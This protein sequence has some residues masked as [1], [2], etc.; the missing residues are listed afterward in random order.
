[1]DYKDT[2]WTMIKKSRQNYALMAPYFILFFTFTV[3]PVMMA[4]GLSFTNFN[5]LQSPTFVGL[6]N[7]RLLLLDDTF[8]YCTRISVTIADIR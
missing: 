3:L 5:M 2:K 6:N 7:Y 8:E 1:M 4:I